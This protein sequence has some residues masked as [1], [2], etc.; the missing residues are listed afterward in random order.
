MTGNDPASSGSNPAGSAPESAGRARE[1]RL[2]GLRVLIAEDEYLL[3]TMLEEDLRAAGCAILG[4]FATLASARRAAS[5][6]A[7]DLAVLDVNLNGEMVYALAEELSARGIPFLF[8]SG[9][10]ATNFPERFRASPHL[11]KPYDAAV[12]IEEIRRI[13]AKGR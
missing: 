4:S 13:A 10:S 3:A 9:Y 2:S 6:E 5:R 8:L 7:F 12:L 11:S 1:G